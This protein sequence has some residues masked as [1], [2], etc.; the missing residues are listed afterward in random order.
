MRIAQKVSSW[1]DR[2]GRKKYW[3]KTIL[4]CGDCI[5][6][7]IINL[8]ISN[9]FPLK[10]RNQWLSCTQDTNWH[11]PENTNSIQI[12]WLFNKSVIF[13]YHPEFLYN[14]ARFSH[15]GWKHKHKSLCGPEII[16][17][18][19]GVIITSWLLPPWNPTLSRQT[20]PCPGSW[21]CLLKIKE[22]IITLHNVCMAGG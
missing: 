21:R 15:C 9:D 20:H 16:A 2:Q 14:N 6:F 10:I 19:F 18:D 12:W 7:I 5:A 8:I 11:S 17:S 13:N 3:I 4:I 22:N 1:N